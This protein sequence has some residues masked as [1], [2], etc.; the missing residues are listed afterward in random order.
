MTRKS[1]FRIWLMAST[2]IASFCVW[3]S[4]QAQV[5][6]TWVN[7][8]KLQA[9]VHVGKDQWQ[10]TQ[11]GRVV[12]KFK[13]IAR[14]TN[15]VV[16]FDGS[17]GITVALNEG[18][19]DISSGTTTFE[20]LRGRFW[21]K[22]WTYADRTGKFILISDKSWQEIQSG[23]VAF[24]FTQTSRTTNTVELFDASRDV[25]VS[26]APGRAEVTQH[27]TSMGGIDG[28]WTR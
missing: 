25:A 22:E 5:A 15:G 6:D 7:T 24:K 10:E 2:L 16:L 21:F 13:E 23:K 3:D 14:T 28:N 19:A 27:G 18:K 17:R 8:E 12:F 11:N 9:F 1:V 4:A 26:L 20:G